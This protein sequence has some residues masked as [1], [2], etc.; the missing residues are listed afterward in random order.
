[1]IPTKYEKEEIEKERKVKMRPISNWIHYITPNQCD[2]TNICTCMSDII[3]C[4]YTLYGNERHNPMSIV[5]DIDILNNPHFFN[6][7]I[8]ADAT[9]STLAWI[10]IYKPFS[11]ANFSS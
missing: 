10:P 6:D 9:T 1:M 11:D 5:C 3:C 7:I 2:R 4:K 8:Q